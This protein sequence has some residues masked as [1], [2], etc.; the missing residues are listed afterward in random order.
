MVLS[1][2]AQYDSLTSSFN[3][4]Q[5]K[6]KP[7]KLYTISGLVVFFYWYL[8]VRTTITLYESIWFVL[9]GYFFVFTYDVF[10]ERQPGIMG[11]PGTPFIKKSVID[12]IRK[13][14]LGS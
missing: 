7:R 9:A 14:L 11:G 6:R 8:Y 4:Q 10:V 13:F 12:R 3:Y 5:N 2:W 1:A